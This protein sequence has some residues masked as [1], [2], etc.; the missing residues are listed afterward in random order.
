MKNDARIKW[1]DDIYTDSAFTWYESKNELRIT[2]IG[3][4]FPYLRPEYTGALF[5]LAKMS[6]DEYEAY[7]L[8]TED[9]I[10]QFLVPSVSHQLRQTVLL[11]CRG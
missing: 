9:D 7:L 1:Q 3:R 6:E 8:N 4:G 10:Q 5:V 2:K 11:M